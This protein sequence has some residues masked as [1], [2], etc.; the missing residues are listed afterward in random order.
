MK[1]RLILTTALA[2]AGCGGSGAGVPDQFA[3][4]WGADCS[5]PYVKFDGGT[6]HVYPDRADYK[7]KSAALEG[8]DL[9]VAY[10]TPNG[11]LTDIYAS[12]GA[13]LRLTKTIAAGGQEAVWIKMPM[14]KCP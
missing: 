7:I 2:L 3:G 14:S 11:Q 8:S 10:D 5:S 12:E 6:V 4:T 1:H 9:K 13:T